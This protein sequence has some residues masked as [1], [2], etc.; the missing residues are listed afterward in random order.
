MTRWD[1]MS[2]SEILLDINAALTDVW[3]YGGC[4]PDSLIMSESMFLRIVRGTMRKRQWRR[5]RGKY[6]AFKRG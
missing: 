3:E 1:E 4:S 6:K 5:W 2:E